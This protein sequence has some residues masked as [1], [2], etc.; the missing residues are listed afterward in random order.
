MSNMKY[1]TST[2]EVTLEM[3]Y[4]RLKIRNL[5]FPTRHDDQSSDPSDNKTPMSVIKSSTRV[6]PLANPTFECTQLAQQ[7][8]LTIFSENSS[9]ETLK[10]MEDF[11]SNS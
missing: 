6:E 8:N 4:L 9:Q 10:L 11:L 2:G 3:R 5:F 1:Y 7:G